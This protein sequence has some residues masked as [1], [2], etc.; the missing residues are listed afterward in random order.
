MAA[1]EPKPFGK[2]FLT[3][4]LAVGGMA[5]IYKA[6]TFG[7]DGFEKQLAIKKI[8]PHYSADKE[9]IAM[10]TDEAKLVVCL[11][12][13]NIVQIYDLGKV[14]DD[15]YISMEYIDG[16]NL[17]EV[18][19]RG[20]ELGEEIPLPI[21]L[22]IASEICKGLDY[23]H[24]KRDDHGQPLNIVHRDV[25]PQ[26]I[27]ISF[28]SETKIVDFGIAKAAMN[29]S[30]TTAGILKGKITYMSP[31]QALGKPVDN[32]TDIFS[33]G[34]LLFE[35]ITGKRLFSGDTQFEV[36][37]K[38]RTTQ[39]T[40][41]TLEKN[42][43]TNARPILTKAL[44]HLPKDRFLTAGDCQIALTKILY[45]QYSDF[46]PKQ[47]AALIKK[48]FAP[49]LKLK[50]RK[51]HE[52]ASLSTATQTALREA[53]KQESIVH[54]DDTEDSISK[55]GFIQDTTKPEDG[56]T[57]AHLRHGP[58]KEPGKIPPLPKVPRR[59]LLKKIMVATLGL[60]FVA[61]GIWSYFHYT[62]PKSPAIK[63]FG[64][65]EIT[66]KPTGAQIFLN[67]KDTRKKTPSVFEQLELE[68]TYQVRITK[69]G[70]KPFE[71]ELR[72]TSK[73]PVE[74]SAILEKAII[75]SSIIITSTPSGAEILLD[76]KSTGFKTPNTI[77]KLL[78]PN[79]YEISLI[80]ENYEPVTRH[81]DLQTEE[82]TTI[83]F[84]LK[85]L[86]KFNVGKIHVKTN[87]KNVQV[88]LDAND[89][90]TA[91]NIFEIKPGKVEIK[92]SKKGY[93]SEKKVLVIA[94][95]EQKEVIFD[96]IKEKG[97][98]LSKQLGDVS[99]TSTPSGASVF[100]GGRNKGKTPLQVQ[101]A[102][103][104]WT[105]LIRKKGYESH[106]QKLSVETEKTS[107]L[108]VSLK[109]KA[110]TP[111]P[112][113]IDESSYH[114]VGFGKVRIDSNPRGAGVIFNGQKAGITPVVISSVEKNKSH[115]VVLTLP[116]YQKWTKTFNLNKN[117]IELAAQLQKR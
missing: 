11:S 31:E 90:G 59:G 49:E 86:E 53:P 108:A 71:K 64:K 89:V 3:E 36:L 40:E 1:F 74:I 12:H 93:R 116:G 10:L 91:P 21:C 85:L 98:I 19:N 70:F 75:Y 68:K 76:N 54:Y 4:K 28:E 25:S 113:Q 26:N 87:V 105:V 51:A 46:S 20:K 50:K 92:V 69:E 9:F 104:T 66:S 95:G 102:S 47:L 6:K 83:D 22:Y 81:V 106:Q 84:T 18:I 35:M 79:S 5:E 2:Y 110:K 23:A 41:E 37:K 57:A 99:I 27:L 17:R 101:V 39:V 73:E 43:P 58:T 52:E 107:Q 63:E 103:G 33:A 96:L 24:S 88:F 32:R 80:K 42:I 100:I 55:E 67:N 38:I 30:H 7:V 77:E 65:M 94:Q 117:Y 78:I 48:W 29:V 109:A 61:A 45:S 56:I 13:T 8:L 62:T 16:V 82:A 111:S 72:L 44:A 114:R 14:G 112:D 60:A 115:T 97:E 15:Y 34:L